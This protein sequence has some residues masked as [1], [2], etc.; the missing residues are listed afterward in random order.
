MIYPVIIFFMVSNRDQ[1]C[2]LKFSLFCCNFEVGA[3][4]NEKLDNYFIEV[5][6]YVFVLC[7]TMFIIVKFL[8]T[9][10]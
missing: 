7:T 5:V 2:Y 4:M 8:L 3:P 6:S 10:P 1:P 9:L